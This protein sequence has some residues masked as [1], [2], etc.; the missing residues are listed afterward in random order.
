[1][2]ATAADIPG[3]RRDPHVPARWAQHYQR[4]SALRDRFT[5]RDCS[6]SATS[7]AKL[8]DPG[9]AA[10][11]DAETSLSFVAASAT[12]EMLN[13]VL[14]AVRRIEQGT[15]GICERTGQPIEPR[16]LK[17]I[18]WAR[19]SLQGQTEMEKEGLGR[20]RGVPPLNPLSESEAADEE[21]AETEGQAG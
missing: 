13:D 9:E 7:C 3:S 17:A 18:P 2:V 14:D 19:Y 11:E 20:R 6:T 16:R 4:L 8:D 15:F 21:K 5:Q 12:H 10:S 1:M